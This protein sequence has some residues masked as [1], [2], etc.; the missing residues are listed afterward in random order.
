MAGE[1]TFSKMKHTA[2][3]VIVAAFVFMLFLPLLQ[4]TFKIFPEIPSG[5]NRSLAI[6]PKLEKPS[7]VALRQYQKEFEPYFNDNYGFRNILV[8]INGILNIKLFGFSSSKRV[9]L[10]GDGWLFYN[11]ENDGVSFK[12]FQGE[13]AFSSEELTK[14][15]RNILFMDQ[16]LRGK[17]IQFVVILA[18]NKHTIYPEY[19]PSSVRINT[20]AKTRADQLATILAG[21]DLNYID[22]RSTLI[23]AKANYSMPLYF[24]TDTHWNEQGALI[25]Y[26]K[27]IEELQKHDTKHNEL[28]AEIVSLRAVPNGGLG[29]MAGFL[30]LKNALSDENVI[31]SDISPQRHPVSSIS[32]YSGK[33]DVVMEIPASK[34]PRLLVFRDSFFEALLPFICQQFSR[35]VYLWQNTIDLNIIDKEKPDIVIFEFVER[36]SQ[37][38]LGLP[39][40]PI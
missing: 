9:V 3:V 19:L 36:Y 29:D 23:D 37:C 24:K 11:D 6:R 32:P 16:Q 4:M 40:P 33:S 27:I 18:P 22:L 38:L 26:N 8:R 1:S 25:A 14:I 5:E 15:K 31:V 12:D 35:S 2:Y 28:Q 21:S 30:N 7:L 17:G 10:G 39:N 20:G 13:A 34:L